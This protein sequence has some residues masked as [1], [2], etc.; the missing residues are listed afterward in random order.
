MGASGYGLSLAEKALL[1]WELLGVDH[2][3]IEAMLALCLAARGRPGRGG[4]EEAPPPT[5]LVAARD[6]CI[7]RALVPGQRG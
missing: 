3:D 6:R 5:K 1:L 2:K 4:P 7:G